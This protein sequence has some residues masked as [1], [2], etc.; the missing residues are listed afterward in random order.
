MSGRAIETGPYG[1]VIAR[2]LTRFTEVSPGL[3]RGP[4]KTSHQGA[5]GVKDM[6]LLRRLRDGEDGQDL[7]EYALLAALIA[8]VTIVALQG[9]G[10]SVAGFYT[11]LNAKMAAM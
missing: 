8:V 10:V 7:I 1:T 6:N 4:G 3:V 2:P 5:Q 9:L 11:N